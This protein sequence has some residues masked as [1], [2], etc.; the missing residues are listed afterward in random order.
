MEKVTL[1]RQVTFQRQA[2][3]YLMGDAIG[4]GFGYMLW[5]QVIM[6]CS[7]ENSLH[8]IRGGHQMFGREII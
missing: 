2:L 5:G 1:Q 7:N 8:C 4:V 3:A 6:I